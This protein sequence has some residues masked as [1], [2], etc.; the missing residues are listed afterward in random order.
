MRDEYSHKQPSYLKNAAFWDVAPCRYCVN[1]TEDLHIA[2]SQKIAFFTVTAVKTS[3]LKSFSVGFHLP[4]FISHIQDFLG[5]L[6]KTYFIQFNLECS[7]SKTI[8]E[9]N[10][11]VAVW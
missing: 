4:L 9:L 6:F 8:S 2:T 10:N 11:N 1:H 7:G 3:N 5:T